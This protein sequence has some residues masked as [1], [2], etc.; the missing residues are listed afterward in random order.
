MNELQTS[1]I[2]QNSSNSLLAQRFSIWLNLEC[3]INPWN[4]S[5]TL[6]MLHQSL[7]AMSGH[8]MVKKRWT[9]LFDKCAAVVILP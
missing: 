1:E 2:N 4:A 5:S 7:E 8:H 6:G 3:F 9:T